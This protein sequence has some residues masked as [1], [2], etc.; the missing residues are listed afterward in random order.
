MD[1]RCDY[2]MPPFGGIKNLY[3][4]T[5]VAFIAGSGNQQFL[6]LGLIYKAVYKLEGRFQ[7]AIL[8]AL[9]HSMSGITLH[10]NAYIGHVNYVSN[11]TSPPPLTYPVLSMIYMYIYFKINL[12][13]Y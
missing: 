7:V 4:L 9:L 10:L 8:C 6:F 13:N 12:L 11:T 2:Y 3:L 5:L 1:G